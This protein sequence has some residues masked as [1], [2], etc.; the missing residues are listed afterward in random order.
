[1]ND[2]ERQGCQ[3]RT[4]GDGVVYAFWHDN[5]HGTP[6]QFMAR[7]FDGGVKFERPRIVAHVTDVGQFDLVRSIAND[8][9]A[10]ARTNSF[11]NVDIANGAPTGTGAPNTIVLNWTDASNGLNSEEALTQLSTDGGESRTDPVNVAEASDRPNFPAVALSPDGHDLW[12]TYDAFLDPFREDTTS[13]RRFQGV[14]RHADLDPSDGSLSNL[15][16]LER[17]GIGDARASSA[18]GLIDEFIG[19]YNFVAA[20]ND[21]GAAVYNDAR[22]AEVCGDTDMDPDTP[23]INSYRQAIANGEEPEAPAPGTD[24]PATFGNTDI[25]SATAADPSAP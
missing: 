24:C 1:M 25:F 5:D 10:G 4:D 15:T 9:I 19:D 12:V 21:F 20:T 22:N 11:P 17:G 14:F 18:N 8:G 16:T 3:V 7:S 13:T 23:E 2:I 6:V